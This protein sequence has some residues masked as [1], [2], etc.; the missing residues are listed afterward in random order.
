MEELLQA[1]ASCFGQDGGISKDDAA[2]MIWI[3]LGSTV[4]YEE[5][6]K[7]TVADAS[8]YV[9]TIQTLLT[10]AHDYISMNF[11]DRESHDFLLIIAAKKRGKIMKYAFRLISIA[12]VLCGILCGCSDDDPVRVCEPK[13]WSTIFEDNFNSTS[14]NA[15]WILLDGTVDNFTLDGATLAMD[16]T[17]ANQQGPLFVYRNSVTN[18]VTRVTCK[19]STL[20]MSGIVQFGLIVR[21]DELESNSYI[22]YMVGNELMLLKI[23]SG[24]EFVLATES[25]VAMG[26]DETRLIEYKYD[27]GT[28]SLIIKDADGGVLGSVT[29]DDPSPHPTGKAGFVGEVEGS[30]D[31]Y[32][33]LDDFKLEKYE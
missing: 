1:L 17:P 10:F 27:K 11:Y 24:S 15:D 13:S 18:D 5:R 22:G 26:P 25:V 30:S 3:R 6:R 33:Y 28:I 2:Q 21:G 32:L 16:D 20:A 29:S 14:L 31:E 7:L 19:I 23:L 12:L 4:M 8:P 9:K